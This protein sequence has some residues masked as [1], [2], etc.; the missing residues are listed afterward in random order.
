M[1]TRKYTPPLLTRATAWTPERIAALSTPELRQL[2]ANAQRLQEEDLAA[3]CAEALGARPR[4]FA[5]TR[6]PA[7][8]RRKDEPRHLVSRTLAFGMH[9]VTLA[10]R[11]WSR[12]G[13]TA[14]GN[15]MFTVWAED[16]RRE[17][18]AS[19]YLLWA[20][21]VEGSRPW[22]DKPGGRER[23]EHCRRAL[24]RGTADGL[25]VFGTRLEGVLPDEKAQSVDGA[26]AASVRKMNIEKIGEE[27]W[28]S[29]GG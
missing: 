11:Y 14:E 20:P 7:K 2:H 21:N 10:N 13:L 17:G 6:T 26:D 24:E 18:G 28:G 3:Q 29:W 1:S 23:L 15:V 8:R 5:V 22:S 12:S 27:Y 4:G 16:V 19:R 9:G 25:F